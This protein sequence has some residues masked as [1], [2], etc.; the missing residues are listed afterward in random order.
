MLLLCHCLPADL[1]LHPLTRAFDVAALLC[2]TPEANQIGEGQGDNFIAGAKN[3]QKIAP[4]K[5]KRECCPD[6]ADADLDAT[7]ERLEADLKKLEQ[8]NKKLVTC[9][10]TLGEQMKSMMAENDQLRGVLNSF[11]GGAVSGID[12]KKSSKTQAE[13]KSEKS[14]TISPT[15]QL[16]AQVAMLGGNLK[17]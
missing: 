17:K 11:S 14:S 6:V 7:A 10:L 13:M 12:S 8:E 1:L 15:V 3:V 5:R 4:K 9:F 16:L 2:S